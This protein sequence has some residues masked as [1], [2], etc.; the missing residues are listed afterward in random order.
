MPSWTEFVRKYDKKT[1]TEH[2]S[3]QPIKYSPL[4]SYGTQGRALRIRREVQTAFEVIPVIPCQKLA[5]FQLQIR[6]NIGGAL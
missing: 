1:T 4:A 2:A 3:I 6:T 5:D